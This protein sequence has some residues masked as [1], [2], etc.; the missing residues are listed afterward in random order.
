MVVPATDVVDPHDHGVL[1]GLLVV[2]LPDAHRPEP[3][4]AVQ[5][6]RSPVGHPHLQRDGSGTHP[7]GLLDQLKQDAR[8][9]LAPVVFGIH[10]DGGYVG[11]LAVAHDPAVS[12]GLPTHLGHQV[13]AASKL[14]HLGEEQV[15]TPRP[16]IDLPLDGHYALEV[17]PAH[18]DD[19]E[20]SRLVDRDPR[21]SAHPISSRRTVA[22]R[23]AGRAAPGGGIGRV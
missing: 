14:A 2:V 5:A 21:R 23:T 19:L 4:P 17:A 12:H 1:A 3:E 18:A 11:F 16:R 20:L 22:A 10:R 8:A 9:D 6:L 7:D 15:G 13:A